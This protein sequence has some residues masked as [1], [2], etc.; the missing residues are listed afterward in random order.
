MKKQLFRQAA[1]ERLSSPEQLDQLMHI[2]TPRGWLALVALSGLLVAGLVWGILGRLP[3]VVTAQGVLVRPGG[4]TRIVAMEAGQVRDVYVDLGNAVQAGQIV[5]LV[6]GAGA[7][8]GQAATAGA[9]PSVEIASPYAG[10]VIA[11]T[12]SQGDYVNPGTP[13]LTLGPSGEQLELVLYVPFVEGIKIRPGMP[14]QIEV[15]TA[16]KEVYGF[17]LGSVRSVAEFP[18]TAEGMKR[19]LGTDELVQTFLAEGAPIEIHVD[20]EPDAN[21]P[22]G[23]AWSFSSGP[24]FK[25]DA[26]TLCVARVILSERRPISLV[27]PAAE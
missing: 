18:A 24:D 16:K 26:G 1:L 19:I 23:Y 3:V 22:S 13:L 25:L 10:Q 11:V 2:A 7:A 20:L 4:V 9:G 8:S 27:L 5:A 15:L 6:Q 17:L 21:A 14:V 12:V